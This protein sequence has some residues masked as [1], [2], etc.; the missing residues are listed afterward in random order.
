MVGGYGV[1]GL[2][3]LLCLP[4]ATR[5]SPASRLYALGGYTAAVLSGTKVFTNT[6]A[7]FLVPLVLLEM[8]IGRWPGFA[9]HPGP[10]CLPCV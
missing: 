6:G 7:F 5:R 2:L 4:W 1:F 3:A 9:R 10:A 8:L